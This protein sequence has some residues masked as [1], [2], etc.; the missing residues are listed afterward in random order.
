MEC[1][2]DGCP[3]LA[4]SDLTRAEQ[5]VQRQ[6]TVKKMTEQGFTQEQIAKQLGVTQSTVQRDLEGLPIVGKPPR[7]KGGRPSGSKRRAVPKQTDGQETKII[8]L[9]DSGVTSEKIAAEIGVSGRNV[10]RVIEKERDKREAAPIDA[11]TLSISAQEKV[12]RVIRQFKATLGASF[13]EAVAN[14]VRERLDEM[15][16]P[17]QRRLIAEAQNLYEKRRGLMNKETFNTIR[18]ALHADSRNSISDQRL[19]EAFNNFMALEK[20]LLNEADS[21][22]TLPKLP[23]NLA[24]W[25]AMKR[26]ARAGRKAVRNPVKIVS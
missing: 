4:F 16:L 12:D 26:S 24:E 25:D 1:G 21:P 13:H 14:K 7:P 11:S 18:R 9:A 6:R 10:R 19:N 22:T 17:E 8:A 2:P 15:I 23:T 5:R 3:I 20:Y